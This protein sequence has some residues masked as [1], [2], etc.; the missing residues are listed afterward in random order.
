ME[1]KEQ[2]AERGIMFRF[3]DLEVWKKGAV[4]ASALYRVADEIEAKKKF[5]FAEQLRGA[6]RQT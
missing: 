5:R 2:E 1:S 6:A 4:V 3:E